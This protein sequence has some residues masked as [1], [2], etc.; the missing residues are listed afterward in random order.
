M[1]QQ[2]KAAT[3]KDWLRETLEPETIQDLAEYGAQAG[4]PGL[5]YYK[6]TSELYE[7]F[8]DE[9]WDALTEDAEAFGHSGPIEFVATFRGTESGIHSHTQFVNLLVWY[10]AERT[11]REITEGR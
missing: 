4:F 5:T 2:A 7:R 9:I 6:D 10:M 3:F 8:A 1:N 11:A